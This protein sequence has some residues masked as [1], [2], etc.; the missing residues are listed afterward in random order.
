[1]MK[2]VFEYS[3]YSIALPLL[4]V[5]FGVRAQNPPPPP[6]GLP[7]APHPP[8]NQ[9]SEAKRV[10]GK[11]L[12]WDEQLSSTN[13]MA[14][15]TCHIP[16]SGGSDP[17]IGIHPGPDNQ[18]DTSDDIVGS[19][20]VVRLDNNMDPVDDPL[21]GFDPQVTN[22]GAPNNLMAAFSPENFWDGRATSEFV[23]PE[24]TETVL[25]AAGGSLESQAVGPILSSVEMAHEGRTWDDVRDKLTNAIPMLLASDIPSDMQDALDVNPT[26]PDLFNAAFGDPGINGGRIAFAIASYQRTLEPNQTPWDLFMQGDNSAMTAQQK[27]GWEFLRDETVCFNCHVPPMFTDHEFYNLGLR[28][29]SDDLGRFDVTGVNDDKGRFKTPSLRNAGLR[30]SM[31][32]VGW[33]FD[34]QDMVH[35]YNSANKGGGNVNRHVQFP[36]DQSDIPNTNEGLEDID[37]FHTEQIIVVEFLTNALTDPRVANEDFPFDRPTLLSEVSPMATV[38]VD[39][40]YDGFEDGSESKPYTTIN[41][42]VVHVDDAGSIQFSPGIT[43]GP[44]VITKPVNLYAESGAVQIGAE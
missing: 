18:F 4:I 13:T 16:S 34:I 19:P 25:I 29:S 26:Y 11:M 31:M 2:Q 14:C 5:S 9:P 41:E 20:G 32:H 24:D 23:D 33:V 38:Y 42:A 35:F 10:L 30:S 17:R 39:A 7:P 15:G 6:P 43:S 27:D 40:A 37:I 36:D 8:E 12:F 3:V 28:P 21:F 22:R 1:M 44:V